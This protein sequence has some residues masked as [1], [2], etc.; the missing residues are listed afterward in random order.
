MSWTK[1][2]YRLN[3]QVHSLVST[4]PNSTPLKLSPLSRW[5]VWKFIIVSPLT[6]HTIRSL[7]F[8]S[9][10]CWKKKIGMK[11]KWPNC[12]NI[13]AAFGPYYQIQLTF[14]RLF[15]NIFKRRTH[16][17]TFV[18]RPLFEMQMA[19]QQRQ[20]RFKSQIWVCCLVRM[21]WRNSSNSSASTRV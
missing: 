5:H 3:S 9:H 14:S 7:P 19:H 15:F 13:I 21:I 16:T 12:D 8:R 10:L 4:I 18:L 20:P 6:T 11:L 1:A 2:H 17:H